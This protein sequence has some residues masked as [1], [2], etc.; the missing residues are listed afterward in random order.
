MQRSHLLRGF[1]TREA[2]E[3]EPENVLAYRQAFTEGAVVLRFSCR[4]HSLIVPVLVPVSPSCCGLQHLIPVH[5]AAR[6]G[7]PVAA[8]TMKPNDTMITDECVSFNTRLSWKAP[9]PTLI[10]SGSIRVGWTYHS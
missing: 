7:F 3:R 10:L 4:V 8:S 9:I 6:G 1:S 5:M 2:S